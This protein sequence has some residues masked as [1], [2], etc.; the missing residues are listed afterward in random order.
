MRSLKKTLE[1]STCGAGTL[2]Y[3]KSVRQLRVYVCVCC[4]YACLRVCRRL[5]C[6]YSPVES[7]AAARVI[8][9]ATQQPRSGLEVL[10]AAAGVTVRCFGPG[11]DV[12]AEQ[13][14]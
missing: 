12:L 11:E 5:C 2:T 13:A 4:T 9:S 3:S 8:V 6:C 14:E 1:R 7:T 10:F